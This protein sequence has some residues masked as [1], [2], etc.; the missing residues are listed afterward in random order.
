MAPDAKK[1]DQKIQLLPR[2]TSIG[3]LALW[4]KYKVPFERGF[5]CAI[6]SKTLCDHNTHHQKYKKQVRPRPAIPNRGLHHH[7]RTEF[8][9]SCL[10]KKFR[11]RTHTYI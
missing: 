9:Y 10:H 5:P 11:P 7:A 1:N 4:A 3:S 6:I 2:I 8:Y